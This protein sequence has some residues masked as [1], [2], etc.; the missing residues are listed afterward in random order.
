[1]SHLPELPPNFDWTI[2]VE[3]DRTTVNLV[4]QKPDGLCG[5]IIASYTFKHVDR[6][7]DDGLLPL[8]EE[9]WRDQAA[10]AAHELWRRYTLEIQLAQWADRLLRGVSNEEET[11]WSERQ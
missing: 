6:N 3:Y 5:G 8:T 4:H 11:S 7:R 1:M 10:Y 9:T 2:H